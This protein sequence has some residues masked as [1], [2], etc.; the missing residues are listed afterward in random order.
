MKYAIRISYIGKGYSGWQIQPD[1]RSIQE[2]IERALFSVT[3]E[4]IRIT[5][6]GRTDKGVN[7]LG[8]VASFE[9]KRKEFSNPEKL[10]LALNFHLPEDIRI[11]EAQE[12]SKEFNARYSAKKREYRYFI[13]EGISCPPF[14]SD[15]VW[16]RKSLTKWDLVLAKK[17]C[18]LLEGEHNF[19]S[20]CREEECP[21]NSI[22]TLERVKIRK[23]KKLIMLSVKGKSFLTNMIRIMVGN[24]DA[25][26]TGK[27]DLEWLEGLLEGKSRSE[28]AM[29][30][31]AS[32]LWFWGV[33]Y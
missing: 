15:Y 11:L 10:I 2:E 22:R 17:A 18:K 3:Q 8:Q 4:E 24:I 23:M 27:R 9:I 33:E 21:E 13:Y 30:V 14:L 25:V 16:W 6:A 7:A 32:G 26:A 20:F 29:T 31:P 5:G 12:V 28:S 1:A 19:R